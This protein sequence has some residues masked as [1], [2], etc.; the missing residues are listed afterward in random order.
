MQKPRIVAPTAP[1]VGAFAMI[2]HAAPASPSPC[3]LWPLAQQQLGFVVQD[4][5]SILGCY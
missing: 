5:Q 1:I 4:G 2:F 3:W